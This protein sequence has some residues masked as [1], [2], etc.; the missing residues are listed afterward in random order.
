MH[1]ICNISN[2][3]VLIM[4]CTNIDVQAIIENNSSLCFK[5]DGFIDRSFGSGEGRIS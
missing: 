4:L 2:R 5:S 1:K 3:K